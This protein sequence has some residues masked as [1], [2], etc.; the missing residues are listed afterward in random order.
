[1]N[2]TILTKLLKATFLTEHKLHEERAFGPRYMPGP[3]SHSKHV[4]G[5]FGDRKEFAHVNEDVCQL[6]F[7]I[8][9]HWSKEFSETN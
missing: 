2:K 5:Y 9:L 4:E 8:C 6:A 7:G 1:M 3:W